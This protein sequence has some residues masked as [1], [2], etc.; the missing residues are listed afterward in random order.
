MRCG[1]TKFRKM[2][3]SNAGLVEWSLTFW[4]CVSPRQFCGQWT[5]YR[6]YGKVNFRTMRPDY[7]P[8][9]A[10]CLLI[11]RQKDYSTLQRY[12]RVIVRRAREQDLQKHIYV[13]PVTQRSG[14]FWVITYLANQAP[15]GTLW[16]AGSPTTI[17]KLQAFQSVGY[18]GTIQECPAR[19]RCNVP[20]RV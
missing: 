12:S 19:G 4:D 13:L 18:I 10:K 3:Y 2:P 7:S 9:V 1:G 8:K 5:Y 15:S 11:L 6:L 17:L 14:L 16:V 20:E